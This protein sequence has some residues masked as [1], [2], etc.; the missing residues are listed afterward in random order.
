VPGSEPNE[1]DARPDAAVDAG[2]DDQVFDEV[3]VP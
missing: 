2:S 3:T 1:P